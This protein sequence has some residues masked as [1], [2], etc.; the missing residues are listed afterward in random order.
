M[1]DSRDLIRDLENLPCEV[2]HKIIRAYDE[3]HVYERDD[4]EEYIVAHT[5]SFE[6]VAHVNIVSTTEIIV[7]GIVMAFDPEGIIVA[8]Y[9][10][11]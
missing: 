3:L 1:G 7:K 11:I 9:D 10:A 2:R 4:R 6:G 5:V 8:I